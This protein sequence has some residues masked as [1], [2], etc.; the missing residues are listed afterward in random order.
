M[1]TRH[2]VQCAALISVLFLSCGTENNSKNSHQAD[3]PA[4]DQVSWMT[5]EEAEKAME[6]E[7]KDIYVMVYARWCPH[8]KKFDQTTYQ[9]PKVIKDLNSKFYPVK[10]NAHSN[11][12]ITYKGRSFSNPNYDSSKSK[13]EL[14][15]YHE[16]VY[17]IKA[18]SIPSIVFIDKNLNVKG[19]ELGFKPAD[20]LRSLMAMYKSN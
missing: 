14:N 19:T 7:P 10:L 20:E 9:D 18:A 13:D 1:F 8:C 17:E 16:I 12:K 11:R 4:T 6:K 15:A 3:T 2:I 5:I